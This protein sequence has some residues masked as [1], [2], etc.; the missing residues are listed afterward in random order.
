MKNKL[1]LSM[2]VLFS[3]TF[4]ENAFSIPAPEDEAPSKGGFS[5]GDLD[6]RVSLAG[7]GED[8]D[9]AFLVKFK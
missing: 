1:F 6:H 7:D 2:F 5:L 8:A 3:F 4:V 9:S